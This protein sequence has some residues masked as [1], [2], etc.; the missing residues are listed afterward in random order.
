MRTLI[1]SLPI[2]SHGARSRISRRRAAL[3]QRRTVAARSVAAVPVPW[4]RQSLVGAFPR[5]LHGRRRQIDRLGAKPVSI[6]DRRR[7]SRHRPWRHRRVRPRRPSGLGDARHGSKLPVE[8]RRGSH[9][10]HGAQQELRHQQCRSDLLVGHPHSAHASHRELI[11]GSPASL[12]L[13]SPRPLEGRYREARELA[14][15]GAAPAGRFR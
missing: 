3:R 1:A 9:R 5:G 7:Q 8:R 12:T 2:L 6:R 11:P 14:G 4:P 15:R 10:R 13:R